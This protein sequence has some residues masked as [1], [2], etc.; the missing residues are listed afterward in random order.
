MADEQQWTR[1][2]AEFVRHA[3]EPGHAIG[4]PVLSPLVAEFAEL[5]R[6]LLAADTV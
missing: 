1:D 6:A 5:S 2:K 3:D 4:N